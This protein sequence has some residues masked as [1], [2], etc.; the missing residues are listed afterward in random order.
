MLCAVLLNAHVVRRTIMRWLAHRAHIEWTPELDEQEPR[1]DTEQ[2][3][4]NKRDD[5]RITARDRETGEMSMLWT[6]EIKV[7]A[8]FH[9]SSPLVE[10]D[11]ANDESSVHQVS[12]YDAWLATQDVRNKAG[13]VLSLDRKAEESLPP[14][15]QCTW[16]CVTWAE[17][18]ATVEELLGCD[19]LPPNEEMIARHFAGFIRELFW[20]NAGMGDDQPIRFDDLA[21]LRAHAA[22]GAETE[23]RVDDL[24]DQ[25]VPF[26]EQSGLGR[27]APVRQRQLFGTHRRSIVY[28]GLLD[29]GVQAWISAGVVADAPLR[30]MVWLESRPRRAQKEAGRSAIRLLLPQLYARNLGWTVPDD[31]M[32]WPDLQLR[33]P[34]DSLLGSQRQAESFTA[35]FREGFEDL[36]VTGVAAALAETLS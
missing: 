27:G 21:L 18:G 13:F 31:L 28:R 8:G 29:D 10:S 23:Q 15:L 22:Y 19:A 12:N 4:V 36:A 5:L 11:A 32:T 14:G 30:L 33:M 26:L 17:L 16:T 25:L 1:I 2:Y 9:E 35:F 6:I 24:V 20:E 3:I 34:M 7:G